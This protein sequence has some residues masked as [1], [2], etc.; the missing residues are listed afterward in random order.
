MGALVWRSPAESR[1]VPHGHIQL[2][3]ATGPG[4][5]DPDLRVVHGPARR[6]DRAGRAAH[7]PHR[8][9][10]R[11]GHARVDRE[12]LHARIRGATRHG[13]PVRRH[14]RP[15]AH[16]PDR[17]RRVHRCLGS[18]RGG[19]DRRGTRGGAHRAGR[20][21]GS[22]GAAGAFEYPGAVPAER[23]RA[24]VRHHGCSDRSR[25]GRR[26]AAGWVAGDRRYCRTR[27]AQCVSHQRAGRCGRLPRGAALGAQYSVGIPTAPG[28]SGRVRC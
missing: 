27:L 26:A 22:D 17:N 16:L 15:T 12:R 6:H 7:D 8:P 25:G 4:D 9:R 23:T 11:G 19:A 2:R 1:E 3:V 13:W 28:Y 18:R 21:R 5:D 14:H 24:D 10:H 20:I